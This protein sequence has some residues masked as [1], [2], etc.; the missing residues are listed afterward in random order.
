MIRA[1]TAAVALTA[2]AIVT[3][4]ASPA[5]AAAN[6]RILKVERDGQNISI[7]FTAQGIAASDSI[8][9]SSVG[10]TFNDAPLTIASAKPAAESATVSRAA[11]LVIDTSGSMAGDGIA[12]AKSAAAAFIAAVPDDVE[13][14]LVT[15]SD[16]PQLVSRP[17]ADHA[18]IESAVR[19]LKVKGETAL[20]D[21]AVLASEQLSSY[22]AKTIV[23][24]TD[25]NDTTSRASL[26]SAS[27]TLKKSESVV[28]AI[29]FRTTD[30]QGGPLRTLAG[31]TG[32]RVISAGAA[33]AL[34]QA[35]RQAAQDIAEQVVI[36]AEVPSGLAGQGGTIE[37]TASAGG[38]TLTDSAFVTLPALDP[39]VIASEAAP[40]PAKV[41]TGGLKSSTGLTIALVL[42]FIALAIIAFFA[43]NAV[44]RGDGKTR[45]GRRLSIYTLTGRVAEKERETTA[46]GESNV[47]RSAV[48]LA[49]RAIAKRDFESALARQLEASAVPLRPAEWLLIQ[50]GV[51]IAAALLMFL[52]TGGKLVGTLIGLIIGI[53]LPLGFL[54]VKESRR[55]TAFLAALPDTLQL[56]AGSLSAGYSLPQAVDTVVAEGTEPIAGEFKRALI[57][58]RLGVPIEDALEGIAGR[59]RS[60]DFAWV[61]MAIRIQREVGGNLAEVLV[62]T[63]D[64]LRE[65]ERIRRQV[66]VLSAEGRLSAWILGGLPIVF[67]LYLILVR[68]EYVKVLVT[69][70]IGVIMLVGGV[71]LMT[72]GAF[73]LRKVVKV[74][75]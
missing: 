9:P 66:Q 24:L 72:V 17:T 4:A 7:L 16:R 28:D 62:T 75:V 65:R 10:V 45:I 63:A 8:D 67:A 38:E 53:A 39:G 59:I 61:V 50:T 56:I 49:G 48:D 26:A 20:Y 29:G 47:A 18:A 30:A 1:R 32:G 60:K 19:A 57:E 25:G 52:L 42:V 31:E 55:Q 11:M 15:F 37:V 3:A 43:V 73:W 5:L 13:V 23:L 58:T 2:A 6:G 64:T 34:A 12:G 54:K 68:P 46:F 36:A 44:R 33:D 41:D 27:Q 70:S 21:A 74:D 71:I 14:G 35:F 51:M 40:K 22:S 69:D